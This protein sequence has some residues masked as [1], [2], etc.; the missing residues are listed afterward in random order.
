M[1]LYV[2]NREAPPSSMIKA[3]GYRED[4]RSGEEQVELCC[5]GSEYRTGTY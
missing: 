5:I 4:D 1:K 2:P 3:R